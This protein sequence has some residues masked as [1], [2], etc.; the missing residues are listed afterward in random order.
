[1]RDFWF[2]DGLSLCPV[3]AEGQGKSPGLFHEGINPIHEAPPSSPSH[4]PK[5]SPPNSVT[6]GIRFQQLNLGGTQRS[7]CSSFE[8]F[9]KGDRTS[10]KLSRFSSF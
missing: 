4:L 8:Q 5:A 7:V 9:T 3:M 1:M 10:A 2:T 6:L